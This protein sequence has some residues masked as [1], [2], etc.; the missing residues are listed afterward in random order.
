MKKMSILLILL[1]SVSAFTYVG[2]LNDFNVALKLADIEQK[3]AI[4][5]FSDQNCSYCVKFEKETLNDK[6]V[7]EILKAQYVFVQ[8]YKNNPGEVS[9]TLEGKTQEFSYS[10]LYAFFEVRGTP[11]FWFYTS[12]GLPLT[13]L[14]GY[15]PAKDFIPIVQFL[16]EK[17]YETTT[18]D[19]YRSQPS[20][21]TGNS[22]LV[23]VNREDYNFVLE[24]DPLA[25]EYDDQEFD[26]Y[27]VWL[28][29][30][31][32]QAESLMRQ[33]AHRVILLSES[34]Q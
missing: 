29:K 32:K 27:T 11:T 10:E 18:F 17:A 1:F 20:D 30:D 14:P 3:E 5:M 24:N 8:I 23:E 4:I 22:A 25:K 26:P 21:Y 15:V 13:S 9:L 28:S 16:G 31:K 7:Q 33:G 12:E 6:R 19:D 34:V 2:M